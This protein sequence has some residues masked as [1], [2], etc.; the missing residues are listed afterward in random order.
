MR[1]LCENSYYA[2]FLYKGACVP[3]SLDWWFSDLHVENF[4][5]GLLKYSLLGPSP[6]PPHSV[7]VK[8]AWDFAFLAY[9]LVMQ[10]L[11][12]LGPHCES[13]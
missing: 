1:I 13:Y 8:G 10:I 2:L 11:L 7:G 9:S 5:E 12:A 4:S 6:T 3:V